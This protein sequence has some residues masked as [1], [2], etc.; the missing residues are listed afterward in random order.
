MRVCA[1]E[2]QEDK[3]E[4]RQSCEHFSALWQLCVSS[5]IF[6][7]D[8]GVSSSPLVQPNQTVFLGSHAALRLDDSNNNLQLWEPGSLRTTEN[9]KRSYFGFLSAAS[10][11]EAAIWSLKISVLIP[12]SV[13][14]LYT[15]THSASTCAASA[16]VWTKCWHVHNI[17]HTSH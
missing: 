1:G 9:P 8:I 5:Y 3:Q 6:Q 10:E 14:S 4:K 13:P 11:A 17:L 2:T 7:Q 15:C 12:G 16:P